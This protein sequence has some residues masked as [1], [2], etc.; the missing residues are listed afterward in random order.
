[1]SAQPLTLRARREAGFS[2]LEAMLA[3]F[4]LSLVLVPALDGLNTGVTAFSQQAKIV[5]D[6]YWA[7]GK[8]EEVLAEP[9]ARLDTAALAA[10]DVTTPT[11]YSDPLGAPNRRLVFLARYDGDDTD[12]DG[13]P[14]SGADAGLLFVRVV[15]VSG[16]S[17]LSTLVAR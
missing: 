13:D 14:F 16:D 11:A 12:G 3:L 17:E 1:M 9:I 6:H 7:L 2:Y 10:G 5:V 8:L 4:V 15:V